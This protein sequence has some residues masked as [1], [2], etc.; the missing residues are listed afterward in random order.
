MPNEH[1]QNTMAM[2]KTTCELRTLVNRTNL[3]AVRETTRDGGHP[4]TVSEVNTLLAALV[5]AQR[6]AETVYEDRYKYRPPQ[7]D[8]GDPVAK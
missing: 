4:D 7:E 5:T 3:V 8:L 2:D 1:Q 6:I